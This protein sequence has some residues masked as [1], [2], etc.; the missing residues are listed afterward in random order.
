[1]G[2]GRTSEANEFFVN[3]WITEYMSKIIE[4]IVENRQPLK[5]S[6]HITRKLKGSEFWTRNIESEIIKNVQKNVF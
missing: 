5:F 1:M 6:K 2:G 3:I 4:K